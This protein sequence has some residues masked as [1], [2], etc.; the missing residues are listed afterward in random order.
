[1]LTLRDPYEIGKELNYYLCH[2]D[3]KVPK[4]IKD[5]NNIVEF[6]TK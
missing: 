2:P 4:D 5:D 3:R 1:M 6:I